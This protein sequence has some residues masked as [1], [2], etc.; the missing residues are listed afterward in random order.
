[1]GANIN[2]RIRRIVSLLLIASMGTFLSP[3]TTLAAPPD[4]RAGNI[5]SGRYGPVA[6]DETLS[7]IASKIIEQYPDFTLHQLMVGLYKSNP[8]AF[9]NG[10]ITELIPG[11]M[12][13]LPGRDILRDI[14]AES[15][16]R[17]YRKL[18]EK[19][20]PERGGFDEGDQRRLKLPVWLSWFLVNLLTIVLFGLGS[21]FWQRRKNQSAKTGA[22]AKEDILVEIAQSNGIHVPKPRLYTEESGANSEPSGFDADRPSESELDILL[23]MANAYVEIVRLDDARAILG[24]ILKHGSEY[25]QFEAKQVMKE[26]DAYG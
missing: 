13:S 14:S 22:Q 21:L 8:D 3:T 9:E 12:L 10:R 16:S 26:V 7:R 25:Q 4:A 11:S 19:S 1:M 2:R 17:T 24:H 6:P 15:A 5:A 18:S 23:D 20:A